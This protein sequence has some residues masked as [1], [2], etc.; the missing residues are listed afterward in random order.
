MRWMSD[1]MKHHRR[2]RQA[3]FGLAL[4]AITPAILV[5]FYALEDFLPDISTR[6]LPIT[7]GALYGAV[8][9]FAYLQGLYPFSS[10]SSRE[11]VTEETIGTKSDLPV[12]WRELA[13]LKEDID[14]ILSQ[15]SKIDAGQEAATEEDRDKV[16]SLIQTKLESQALEEYLS[17]IRKLIKN[18]EQNNLLADTF[19]EVRIRLGAEIASLVRRGS[20]NLVFGILISISGVVILWV[21]VD[22]LPSESGVPEI[23]GYFLPRL[24]IVV[25]VQMFAYFFLKLYRQ[26]LSEIKYFQN[27]LT[28]IESK[29][30][31][32]QLSLQHN[33]SRVQANV[34]SV[35]ASTERNF[36]LSKG[37]T[38]VD[39]EKERLN[40]QT[41]R[42]IGKA[43][44]Q[45][46]GRGPRRFRNR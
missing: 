3:A 40:D 35:L 1:R 24:S 43:F 45:Q 16:L 19:N 14:G 6:L 42:A 17:A 37:E 4:L 32:V 2:S 39:I 9:I 23:T 11:V 27:E 20:V 28:N 25:L 21:V 34:V 44:V 30:L 10:K 8:L 7:V 33:D 22:G 26:S 31:S 29:Y 15:F 12:L 38:T 46:Q 5:A 18:Q 13:K 41:F 36:V